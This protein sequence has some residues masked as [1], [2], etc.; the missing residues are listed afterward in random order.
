MSLIATV[1]NSSGILGIYGYLVKIEIDTI[2]GQPSVSIVGM[3]DAAVK[4]SRERLEA[5]KGSRLEPLGEIKITKY[6]RC[7]K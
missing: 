6:R 4:E 1:V 5:A 7:T 3:G 2:Y